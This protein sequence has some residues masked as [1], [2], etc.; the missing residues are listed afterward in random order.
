MSEANV[1]EGW[2]L[3][4]MDN[5]SNVVSGGTPSSK[6]SEYFRKPTEGIAW[7]TPADLSNYNKKYIAHGKRDISDL[8]YEKSSAKLIPKGSVLFTSRAPI[9][10][11]V[12]AENEISTN[13][14]FKSFVITKYTSS[15]YLYYYLK[16]LKDYANLRGTGTTFKEISGKTCKTF[17]FL[18]PPLPEQQQIAK[19][20]DD[21]LDMVE[22]I[23]TKLGKVQS[24]LVTFR[25]SVLV[26]AVSGRLTEGWREK[27]QINLIIDSYDLIK[28]EREN[29]YGKKFKKPV[30]L[31][32]K[33]LRKLPQNW[34]WISIDTACL[35]ITDGTHHSPK[36]HTVGEYKYITS[37]NVRNGFMDLSK[38]SYV[39]EH[40]HKEIYSRCDV[41]LGDVLLVKDG[42]NTGLCCVNNLSEPFS[43][44]SSV[45]LLRTAS[46]VEAKYLQYYFWSPIGKVFIEGMMGGTAIKRLTLTKIMKLPLSLP[47][48][49]EQSEIV[50]RVEEFFALAD[51]IEVQVQSASEKVSLLTQS[52][53][54]KAFRGELTADWRAQ[55]PELVTGDNSAEA[56]L[57]KITE[58]KVLATQTRKKP[59]RKPKK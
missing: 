54:A 59:K 8:G 40:T 1:P 10:Y 26:D 41:K 15:E 39:D 32:D 53:L 35:K 22:V 42:A 58:A 47:P 38:I 5:I 28:K 33:P 3:T 24:L 46:F 44:L 52:I 49:K 50:R 51:H 14:G 12:I 36:T 13:Q 18:M 7:L 2:L 20:L 56:L 34:Q 17:P 9:G 29:L 21:H 11:V 30:F 43:L 55:N 57:A 27:N 45:G 6:V 31:K 16:S 19:L 48:L 4:T 23:K 37:K 25:Q